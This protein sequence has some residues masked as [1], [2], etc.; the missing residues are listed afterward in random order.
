MET[1]IDKLRRYPNMQVTTMQDIGGVRAVLEKVTDVKKIYK[2]Y[3]NANKGFKHVLKDVDDYIKKP[4]PSGYRGIHLIYAYNNPKAP[5]YNGLFV[6][7]QLRTR[8]QHIWATSVETIGIVTKQSLKSSIGTKAWLEFFQLMSSAFAHMENQPTIDVHK[9]LTKDQI[10]ISVANAAEKL[11]VIDKLRGYT[12]GMKHIGTKKRQGFYHL[13]VIN[14]DEHNLSIRSFS[15]EKFKEATKA[16]K[17]IEQQAARGK[18][19]DPVLVG[20]DSI[21]N[22]ERAYPNYF[23]D[24]REFIEN[25]RKIIASSKRKKNKK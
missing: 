1:I 8:L 13:M 7:V 16:Y 20:V 24:S 4:R 25:L 15:K 10:F 6:E 11:N 2:D 17:E 22:L 21:R 18:N 23:L 12:M 5:D 9:H 19:L 14:L 3:M